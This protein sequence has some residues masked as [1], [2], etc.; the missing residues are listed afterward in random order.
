MKCPHCL[1]S[2]HEAVDQKF[3]G[4]DV[5]IPSA[6]TA[7]TLKASRAGRNVKRFAGKKALFA[8]L[9]V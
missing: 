4:E 9:G 2:F 3:L 7:R 8:D 5:H 1:T 6:L